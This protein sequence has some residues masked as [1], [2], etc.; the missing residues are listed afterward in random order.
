MMAKLFGLKNCDSCRKAESWL[1]DNGVAVSFHDLRRDG[2]TQTQIATWLS[3]T[4]I[5][6]MVNKRSTT[7]RQLGDDGRTRSTDPKTAVR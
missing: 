7:W 6:T 5:A 4:D 3:R 2:L 1:K